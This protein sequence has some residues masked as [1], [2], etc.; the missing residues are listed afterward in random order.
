MGI[1]AHTHTH[2]QLI[3]EILIRIEQTHTQRHI[4]NVIKLYFV[5]KRNEN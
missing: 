1:N 5:N 4:L 2:T 3:I